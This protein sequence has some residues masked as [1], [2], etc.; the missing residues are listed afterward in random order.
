M[1]H[2]AVSPAGATTG[3]THVVY[4]ALAGN[5][6]IAVAKL[7]A[8]AASKSS[9]MLAEAIHSFVDS[10]DQIL[11]LIGEAR[12]RRP[13]DA[14]HPLGH[15]MESYFWSFIVAVMVLL[16]GGGASF[17]QGLHRI[18][19]PVPVESPFISVTVLGVAA[20]FEATTLAFGYREFKRVVR[21]RDV[22]L[23]TFIQ[24]SKDPSL[25]GT[26][27]EDSAALVGIAIAALG[28]LGSAV[29]GLRWADGAASLAIGG[30]LTAVAIVLANETR[31]LIAGE[32]VASPV[33]EDI[34]RRL[35]AD[36]R[37]DTVTE[38]ATLHLGPHSVLVALTIRFAPKM[39][40]PDLRRA[41]REL[42]N[43]LKQV[44]GRI[45]YVYVRPAPDSETG[46][47]MLAK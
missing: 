28:V 44:D 2:A 24:A 10:V 40:L 43:A 46:R 26:L 15:G 30:L 4:A 6:A 5:I 38:V 45:A 11:L 25:Y 9:A 3:S 31:S 34:K 29:A 21:G 14:D 41:I 47:N 19:S 18:L 7:I 20:I 39:T 17:Y 37:I 16:L 33:M 23:W 12:G 13:P 22:P 27:L 35:T 42:T 8:F 32:A 36:R 1:R